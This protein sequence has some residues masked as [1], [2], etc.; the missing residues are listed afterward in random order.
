MAANWGHIL[1]VLLLGLGF[2]TYD[3]VTDGMNGYEFL[4]EEE[5]NRTF[6]STATIPL[7]CLAVK[8]KP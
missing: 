1:M 3:V 8:K 2:S 6:G 4:R 7:N 5:V